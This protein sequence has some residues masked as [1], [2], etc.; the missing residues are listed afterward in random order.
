VGVCA[1]EDPPAVACVSHLQDLGLV[2]EEALQHFEVVLNLR[3][4]LG[5]VVKVDS[6]LYLASS[7]RPDC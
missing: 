3:D 6:N 5:R 2:V 1:S 7:I 4:L